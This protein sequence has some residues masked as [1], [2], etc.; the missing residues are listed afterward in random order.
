[1]TRYVIVNADDFGQSSGINQGIITA[2]EEGIVT[3][4]SLMVRW[5]AAAA[6]AAYSHCHPALSLGLHV[7]CEEYVFSDGQWVLTYQ[8]VPMH[9][10]QA[11]AEEV[12]RQLA[13]FRRLVG[14]DPTH[15]DSHQHRHHQEPLRTLLVE[16]AE[17]LRVPLRHYAANIRYCGEFYGQTAEGHSLANVLS[18]QG[19]TNIL[20]QLP[21]GITEL[22]CHPGEA[23]DLEVMYRCE[24]AQEMRVLC[25]P[26]LRAAL[27]T[28]DIELCSFQTIPLQKAFDNKYTE[29]EIPHRSERRLM[30]PESQRGAPPNWRGN[31]GTQY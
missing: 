5:P 22:A 16:M 14:R 20:A 28:L 6:A 13:T 2:Y 24:R 4:A 1:M 7:D 8:V 10:P 30:R 23:D 26:R 18:V 11:V 17:Q 27:S 21:P 15:L 19:L 25:D 29:A 12:W 9:D 31:C 3:S